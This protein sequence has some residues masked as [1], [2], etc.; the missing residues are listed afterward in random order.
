MF[1]FW[2]VLMG[3]MIA[4]SRRPDTTKPM[5]I[6]VWCNNS[7][8]VSWVAKCKPLDHAHAMLLQTLCLLQEELNVLTTAGHTPGKKNVT[9][10]AMSRRFRVAGGHTLYSKLN[11][12]QR[13]PKG[14][15]ISANGHP[16]NTR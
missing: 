13:K 6:H 16:E 12:C 7:S 5:H 11:T 9:A 3:A 2:A 15:R 14:H 4:A 10:D 8:A 1:E